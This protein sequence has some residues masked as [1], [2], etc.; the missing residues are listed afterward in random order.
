MYRSVEELGASVGEVADTK[1]TSGGQ[2]SK[3][4][5]DAAIYGAYSV[6]GGESPEWWTVALRHDTE[7]SEPC[8][9]DSTRASGM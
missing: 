1:E 8:Y 3:R 4:D 9:K 5:G 2:Q 6:E 7:T